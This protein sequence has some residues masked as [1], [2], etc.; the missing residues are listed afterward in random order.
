[1]ERAEIHELA[2]ARRLV[3]RELSPFNAFYGHADLL[4]RYASIKGSRPLKAAIEHGPTFFPNPSDPDLA[5]HLPRYFCAAP[6]QARF[7]EEHALHGAR[8]VAIGAPILYARAL[9]S[10][11]PFA[12]RRLIFFDAHSSHYATANYDV[13]ATAARLA[14]LRSEFDDVVVCLY[15][16]D[17]LLG[18][19]EL[20]QRY[21][22]RC[23]TAGHMFDTQFLFRLVE[24]ISSAS[25]VLTDRLGSHLLY[26][27]ALE[28][29][30]WLEQSSVEYELADDAPPGTLG[31][32]KEGEVLDRAAALFARRVEI[33]EPDQRAFADELCGIT[34]LRS[35]GELADLLAEAEA[36]YRSETPARSRLRLEATAAAR[37]LWNAAHW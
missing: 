25:I 4:R 21:G 2:R 24:I 31:P 32:P 22:F 23:V 35:P 36:S 26:A 8:A 1:M 10:P 9:A 11:K 16:R 15:W 30:V 12:G 29:P 37:H 6:G 18:R 13:G 17:V 20:Y 3:T 7:F 19:A 27:L 34:S 5:T 33:V 28:R 14:E